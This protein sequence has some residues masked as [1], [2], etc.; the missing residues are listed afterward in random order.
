ML[1]VGNDHVGVL[2]LL[3]HPLGGHLALAA[4]N[5][6]FDLGA[7]FHVFVLVLDFLLGHAHA[8]HEAVALVGHIDQGNQQQASCKPEHGVR[9][10]RARQGHGRAYVQ[11]ADRHQRGKVALQ[12]PVQNQSDQAELQNRLDELDQGLG[13]QHALDAAP[14]VQFGKFGRDCCHGKM[15]APGHARAQNR[16]QSREQHQR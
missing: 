9:Y 4:A 14:G 12:H 16:K 2:D 5:L 1:R 11:I 15:V 7:A 10:Q 3:H 13:S 6:L 8:L